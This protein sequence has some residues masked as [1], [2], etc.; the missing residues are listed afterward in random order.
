MVH[1][2]GVPTGVHLT[3]GLFSSRSVRDI[4]LIFAAAAGWNGTGSSFSGIVRARRS[5][6]WPCR[7]GPENQTPDR[8]TCPSDMRGAGPPGGSG[9]GFTLPRASTN[10][11]FPGPR[12]RPTTRGSPPA[13]L[14]CALSWLS[15]DLGAED[16]FDVLAHAL[17][18]AI[19]QRDEG[20]VFSGYFS[21]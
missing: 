7:S 1:M 4:A 16:S 19:G 17:Y 9:T 18:G 20:R 6:R 15:P 2:P 12:P 3:P 10:G 14:R 21:R 8:S 11:F 13:S 5:T